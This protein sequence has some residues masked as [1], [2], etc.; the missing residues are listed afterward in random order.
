MDKWQ[1][2]Q[3]W[4]EETRLRE[5]TG[6]KTTKGDYRVEDIEMRDKVPDVSQRNYILAD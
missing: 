5:T 4:Q 6:G 1:E 3:N 2:E